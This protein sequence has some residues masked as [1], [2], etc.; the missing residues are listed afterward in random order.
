MPFL[1]PL[2]G[3]FGSPKIDCRKKGTLILTSV[4]EDLA[5]CQLLVQPSNDGDTF[6]HSWK[7]PDEQGAMDSSTRL[8]LSSYILRVPIV[9]IWR[10][11]PMKRPFMRRGCP[12]S[13]LVSILRDSLCWIQIFVKCNPLRSVSVRVTHCILGFCL[14]LISSVTVIYS[15]SIW[16]RTFLTFPCWL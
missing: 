5:F 8:V 2:V 12:M 15:P 3:R 6:A 14:R 4:L 9:L 11:S 1:T 16:L 7:P 13:F 10:Y